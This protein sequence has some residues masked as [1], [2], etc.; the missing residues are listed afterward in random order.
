VVW[1]CAPNTGIAAS[2]DEVIEIDLGV[3]SAADGALLD[4]RV[5]LAELRRRG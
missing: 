5:F 3:Q 4:A 2:D 1:I